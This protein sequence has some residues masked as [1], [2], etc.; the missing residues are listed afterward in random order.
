MLVCGVDAGLRGAILIYVMT[1]QSTADLVNYT[2]NIISRGQCRYRA[3]R[4]NKN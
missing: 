2:D 4:G 3:S 1:A